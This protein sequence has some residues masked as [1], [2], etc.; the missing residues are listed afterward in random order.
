[1]TGSIGIGPALK[2]AREHRSKSVDEVARDTMIRSEFINALEREDFES[3]HGDVYVR[4][5]LRSY[6]Q[7]LGLDPDKVLTAYAEGIGVEEAPPAPA[8]TIDPDEPEEKALKPHHTSSWILAG[9]IALL[10]LF[11]F[12]AFGLLSG[13]RATPDPAPL[14]SVAPTIEPSRPVLVE[15]VAQR[16]VE[17]KV[18]IDETV[19]FDGVLN[20]GEA[21]TFEGE[22][23]IAIELAR[24]GVVSIQVNG[25]DLGSPGNEEQPYAEVFLPPGEGGPEQQAQEK[26]ARAED[27]EAKREEKR[28]AREERREAK[29]EEVSPSPAP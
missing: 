22:A 7:Y 29:Q 14:P 24:G 8:P 11:L 23:A 2:K 26:Q 18:T 6:S 16:S 25:N 21:R 1:M 19:D 20:A 3:L 15:L 9:G 17:A 27:R 5:F 28:L 4:G 10:V 12:F 13:S